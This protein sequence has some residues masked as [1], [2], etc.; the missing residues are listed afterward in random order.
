MKTWHAGPFW[1]MVYSG[2]KW[3][4]MAQSIQQTLGGMVLGKP[5]GVD[6]DM[7]V[8]RILKEFSVEPVQQRQCRL[9]EPQLHHN[10]SPRPQYPPGSDDNGDD[11]DINHQKR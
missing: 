10:Q 4:L 1:V 6:V 8:L 2:P 7:I 11:Y 5:H 3:Q 9:Q